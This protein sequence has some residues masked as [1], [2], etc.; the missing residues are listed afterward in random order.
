MARPG[1]PRDVL[2]GVP[3][4]F[5]PGNLTDAG[6]IAA[7]LRGC[8][9]VIHCAADYRIFVPDPARMWA[10]NVAGPEPAAVVGSAL[11]AEIENAASVDAAETALTARVK[12][13][14]HAARQGMSR[15]EDFGV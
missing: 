13:L 5:R 15:R 9:A 6:S 10:V 1:T 14:K 12:L 3:V 11:V 4:E 8:D 2:D 7:A